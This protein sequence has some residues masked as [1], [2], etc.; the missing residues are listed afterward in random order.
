MSQIRVMTNEL[1]SKIENLR[2]LN[3][4]FKNAVTQLES[5]ENN[6][7]SMWEGQANEAFH[8]AFKSDKEQMYNFYSAIELY[9]QKLE[10]ILSRYL[11]AENENIELANTRTYK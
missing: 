11:Q 2:S 4:Q 6:L 5:T 8:N 7:R 10:V 9:A 3:T 1:K